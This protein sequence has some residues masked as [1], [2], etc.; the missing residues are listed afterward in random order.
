MVLEFSNKPRYLIDINHIDS[1]KLPQPTTL[2]IVPNNLT[3]VL[4][5]HTGLQE[6]SDFYM[7]F[8]SQF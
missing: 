5:K 2:A 7:L 3:F 6:Y 1:K 8:R 4:G